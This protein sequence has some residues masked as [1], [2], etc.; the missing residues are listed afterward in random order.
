MECQKEKPR[1]QNMYC[2]INNM[3]S[4]DII[5]TD[6]P[7]ETKGQAGKRTVKF[8]LIAAR[9]MRLKCSADLLKRE[10]SYMKVAVCE[11]IRFVIQMP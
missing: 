6:I 5:L 9:G 1:C 7:V 8:I 2:E 10:F 3:V 4:V 11:D